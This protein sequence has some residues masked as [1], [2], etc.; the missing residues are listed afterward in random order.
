M[1]S[2]IDRVSSEVQESVN[3]AGELIDRVLLLGS[4]VGELLASGRNFVNILNATDDS[5]VELNEALANLPVDFH[6]SGNGFTPNILPDGAISPAYTY[7]A[8]M[9]G[10]F[11]EAYITDPA[12]IDYI[13]REELLE[14]LAE[15]EDDD[16]ST[17]AVFN[18]PGSVEPAAVQDL[19][20]SLLTPKPGPQ[21]FVEFEVQ[22][23][24]DAEEF[25]SGP[26]VRA[27]EY[28]M[29]YI[30]AASDLVID[31]IDYE[32]EG[33]VPAESDIIVD[34]LETGSEHLRQI[35]RDTHFRRA[36]L[37]QQRAKI[38]GI[39]ERFNNHVQ[40]E[41]F[42]SVMS[43]E[44]LYAPV[45]AHQNR[46][47]VPIPTDDIGA[48]AFKPLRVDSLESYGLNSGRRIYSDSCMVDP[49]A[50][51]AIVGEVDSHTQAMLRLQ[52]PVVWIPI[53]SQEVEAHFMF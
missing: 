35:F 50:G 46:Q 3:C 26:C 44:Y 40:L 6:F 7:V 47:I 16:F 38:N 12:D 45:I 48:F 10:R 22:R 32:G 21:L 5:L 28:S 41:R 52:S 23:H 53:S 15:D 25:M 24:T 42:T 33:T 34:L 29:Y 18:N 39:I 8:T 9:T 19:V 13:T 4:Q 31:M 1:Q 30:M 36:S 51:L 17:V 37:R 43:C 11:S 20:D 14:E 49:Q 27:H 2:P